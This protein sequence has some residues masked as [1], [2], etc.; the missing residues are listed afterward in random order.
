[1]IEYLR[2]FMPGPVKAPI[3]LIQ[4]VTSRCMGKCAHCFYWREINK[5]EKPLSP[6]ETY[7][8]ASKMGP[9]LQWL[10][11]GGEP[12][13]R[14]DIDELIRAFYRANR[15]YNIAVATSGYFPER[16][17]NSTDNIF[18]DCAQSNFI[19]GLPVEG[20]AEENDRIRGVE[21]FFDRTVESIKALNDFK[22]SL[23]PSQRAR[24]TVLV[25]ITLSGLN[26]ESAV[27]TYRY[28]RDELKPDAVNVILARGETRDP[29]AAG[30]DVG[31]FAEING[32]IESDLRSGKLRGYGG[33]TKLVNAKDTVLRETAEDTYREKG[34]YYPCAA[35]RLIGVV[36]PEGEVRGCELMPDSF[37][38]L[39]E[40]NYD[41]A[42]IWN[43]NGAKDFRKKILGMKCRCTHQC[44]M[45]P[46][47]FFNPRGALRIM[48]ELLKSAVG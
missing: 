4:F 10:V 16:L 14:N 23:R 3:Y 8:M 24:L 37:G 25:D 43:S 31:V 45:S 2:Y 9:V 48:M 21:G 17:I 36:T 42:K 35:G 32:M 15:P 34:T 13:L 29:E 30:P 1:M 12:Y 28:V 27:E 5:P 41:I 33:F 47:I 18:F 39:R 6:S 20:I 40:K 46:S 22:K 38:N 11:T 19:F 44:F 26:N 7:R